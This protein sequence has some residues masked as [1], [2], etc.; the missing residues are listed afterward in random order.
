[1]NVELLIQSKR[2]KSLWAAAA[3]KNDE[4]NIINLLIT[5][6]FIVIKQGAAG[7]IIFAFIVAF[8][9]TNFSTLSHKTEKEVKLLCV[10][11]NRE[12]YK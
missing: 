8:I 4:K 2:E 11:H 5:Q 10:W 6:L 7:Q 1:M 9:S 3:D 12:R